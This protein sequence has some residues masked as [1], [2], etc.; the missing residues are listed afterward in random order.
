MV[1]WSDFATAAPELAE[2]GR[3]QLYQWDIGLA[4]LASPAASFVTGQT[5]WVDGGLFSQAPWVKQGS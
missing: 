1:T 4:F 3:K 2:V 5:L